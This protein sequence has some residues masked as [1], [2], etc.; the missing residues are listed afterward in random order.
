MS[1]EDHHRRSDIVH[2]VLERATLDPHDPDLFSGIP[3]LDRLFGGPTGLLLT[4]R[5]RW[6]NH[7][8]AKLDQALAQG[9]S[10][11]EAYLELRAEQPALHALLDAQY[12][13]R[14]STVAAMAR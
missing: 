9:Q 6:N 11:T 13:H 8:A 12:G 5:H 4:L 3:D 7:L 10:D 14:D 1:W 2:T